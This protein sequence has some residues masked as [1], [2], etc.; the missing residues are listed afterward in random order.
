MNFT[1]CSRKPLSR[2]S[3]LGVCIPKA[4]DPKG[5]GAGSSPWDGWLSHKS[6][7]PHLE[8]VYANPR[9]GCGLHNGFAF[10]RD[11]PGFWAFPQPVCWKNDP[12]PGLGRFPG[13][14]NSYLLQ[15]SGLDNS[16]DRGVHGGRKELDTTECFHVTSPQSPIVEVEIEAWREVGVGSLQIYVESSLHLGGVT[17]TNLGTHGRLVIRN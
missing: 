12:C 14:G 7:N 11:T 13:E 5:P 10:S 1:C 8:T 4:G 17:L 3:E 6:F 9:R 16:M 2:K 15:Y